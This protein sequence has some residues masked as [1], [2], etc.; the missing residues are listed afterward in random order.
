MDISMSTSLV[1]T[2][3]EHAEDHPW[4]LQ[5]I[6]L[7]GLRLD[8]RREHRLHVWDPE[9][10]S[11]D[12]PVHDHPF[13]FPSTV[14]AGQM[15][16][17]RYE[18][19]PLG[20]EYHRLRYTP[21]NEADRRSDTVRLTGTATT[22]AAGGQ[23]HQ[24]AHELHDSRQVPGTVTVIRMTFTPATPELTVCHR[25]PAAWVSGRSRPAPRTD[26]KRITAAA[27]DLF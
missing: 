6:G 12:P 10:T 17:T 20:V 1:H 19:D 15:T 18:E 27:L 25:E 8:D 23:Y 11:G 3:L 14:I 4:V 9:S 22:I 24:E 21:P 16:N 13:A 5:E 7:L 26:V 2:I